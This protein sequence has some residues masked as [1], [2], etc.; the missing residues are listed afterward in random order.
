MKLVSILCVLGACGGG[1]SAGGDGGGDD[2]GGGNNQTPMLIAG[3]G[4]ADSPIAGKLFVYVVENNSSTPIAGASVRIET[5]TPMT[6]TT[7]AT[8][9]ATFSGVSGK[10]TITATAS[11]YAA[12]TW[13][14]VAGAN[15]TLPL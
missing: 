7:D 3:G 10:Q 5:A 2:D 13:I 11:G 14:G 6:A 1:G 8:G 12:A 15:A 9:L 4:V